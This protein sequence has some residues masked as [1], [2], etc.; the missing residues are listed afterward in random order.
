MSWLNF[1]KPKKDYPEF[2][3]DYLTKI[4][5]DNTEHFVAFDCET[6]GLNPNKDRILSIGAVKFTTERI[7]IKENKEWFLNLPQVE[8]DSIKIHGILPST[9][10]EAL[11]T[12]SQAIIAFLD[13]IGNATLVGHHLNFDIAM[14]NM[15][16]KRLGAGRLK[17]AQKDTNS[18]YKQ[19]GHFAH[20]Q[21]FSLDELSKEFHIKTSNRHTA[22][23]DAYITAQLFQRM[24]SI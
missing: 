3:Q 10:S 7:W 11:L 16:L 18:L 1:L 2:W 14:V 8:N 4:K 19:K 22:L 21:N 5:T 24:C 15:A 20:E 23:G 12:E 17:N 9:S 13:Y 6:T